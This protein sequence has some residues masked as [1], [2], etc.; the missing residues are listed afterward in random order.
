MLTSRVTLATLEYNLTTTG[1]RGRHNISLSK[2][3]EVLLIERAPHARTSLKNIEERLIHLGLG[4]I[5]VLPAPDALW[6]AV[7]RG[8]GRARGQP[9]GPCMAHAGPPAL[10]QKHAF[11]VEE[12][13]EHG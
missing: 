12:G 4:W 1:E 11:W 10:H 6:A 7:L 9:S 13:D 8:G 5:T 2:Q 3:K